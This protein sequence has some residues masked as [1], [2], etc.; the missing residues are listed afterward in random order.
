MNFLL[1]FIR[2]KHCETEASKK[3]MS[4]KQ[5]TSKR[6]LQAFFSEFILQ[7]QLAITVFQLRSY[8]ASKHFHP[9]VTLVLLSGE[10]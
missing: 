8:S 3:V 4:L 6:A 1:L 5:L 9:E 2:G 7:S 10:N